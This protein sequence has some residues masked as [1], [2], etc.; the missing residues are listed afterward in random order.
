MKRKKINW[1]EKELG[2]S[3]NITKIECED[4]FEY[5]YKDGVYFDIYLCSD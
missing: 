3:K 4:S 2:E 5:N 1:V